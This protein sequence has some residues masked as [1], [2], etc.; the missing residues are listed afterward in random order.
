MDEVEH[1]AG[2]AAQPIQLHDHQLVT[3]ANELQDRGEFVPTLAVLAAGLL[4]A[5]DLA[6]CGLEPGFLG[7]VVLIEGTDARVADTGHG[8]G[9]TCHNRVNPSTLA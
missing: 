6:A 4:G 3:G 8:K 9:V 2:R 1:V 7:S 5:D